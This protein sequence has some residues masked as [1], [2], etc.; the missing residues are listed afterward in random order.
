MSYLRDGDLQEV[1]SVLSP[2]AVSQYLASHGWELEARQAEIKEIW[3]LPGEGGLR[4]R[5]M[6][7]LATDYVDFSRRF[8]E[9]LLALTSIYDWNIAQLVEHITSARA[10]LFYVRLDQELLDGTIPFRQAEA[11]LGALFRMMKAAATTADDPLHSHRGRRSAVVTEYLDDGIRLGHTQRGSFVFTV[12]SRLGDAAPDEAA[13]DLPFARKV[14]TTLASD[15]SSVRRLALAWDE[16][17]LDRAAE[18]GL[19][20]NLVESL[21]DLTQPRTLRMVDLSFAWA[22]AAPTPAVETSRIRVDRDAMAGLPLLR[23]RLVRRE[24]PPRRETLF[25]MVRTLNR[26]ENGDDDLDSTSIVLTTHVNGRLRKVQV[27]LA[28]LDYEGAIQAH[29]SKQPIVVTGD[30][31]FERGAW[32]LT[33][34]ISIDPG[35]L[36]RLR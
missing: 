8:K 7:P 9:V 28:G 16:Q 13:S 30:L 25:G 6:L 14:M 21:Q 17:A 15:L 3:R 19:S 36:D 27:P 12:V 34:A 2:S 26:E 22:T 10:D 35:S 18:S 23:E 29:R 33:G 5:I 32:R 24:E 1:T 31:I 11:S 20:A 4:G